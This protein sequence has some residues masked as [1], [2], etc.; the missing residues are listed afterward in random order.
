M[1]STDTN[2]REFI[3][4]TGSSLLVAAAGSGLGL[5]A[6]KAQGAQGPATQTKQTQGATT[7]PEALRMLQKGNARFVQGKM[8]E[9][10]L[11]EQVR[12]TASGQ[13]PIA[14][15]LGCIDSRTI[16]EFIF[17]QGIGDIFNA[18]VAGNFVDDEILGSLEFACAGAGAKLIVVLGHTECGAVKGACDDVI[19]GNLT[20]TLSNIKAAVAAVSGFDPDRDSKNGRFV[21]AVADKHVELTV[22]RIEGR[23]PILRGMIDQGKIG[24][25]GAMYNVHNGSVTFSS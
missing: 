14:A 20:Q 17:D 23:S 7:P 3:N 2:R 18:R 15:I 22:K 19:M 6:M 5:S 9:R 12:A 1:K 25:V 8:L 24:L 21:Q 13:F 4:R 16:S 10:D 11:M